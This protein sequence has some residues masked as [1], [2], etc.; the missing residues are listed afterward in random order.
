MKY[1]SALGPRRP[2]VEYHV[3]DIRLAHKLYKISQGV[4]P[5][6]NHEVTDLQRLTL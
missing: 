3:G 4:A 5:S 2:L 1:G 6:A